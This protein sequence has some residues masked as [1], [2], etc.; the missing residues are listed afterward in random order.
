MNAVCMRRRTLDMENTMEYEQLPAPIPTVL[1]LKP[2]FCSMVFGKCW[3]VVKSL[4]RS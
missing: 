2:N 4:M 1:M 3:R